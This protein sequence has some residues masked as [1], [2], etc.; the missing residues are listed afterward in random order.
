M[1]E[2]AGM[3]EAVH[4]IVRAVTVE[5]GAPLRGSTAARLLQPARF[6]GAELRADE[7]IYA[8]GEIAAVDG[9]LGRLVAMYNAAAHDVAG[10]PG[11]IADE[12]W[13]S[14]PAAL[15]ATSHRVDG[16][17]DGDRLT[18]HWPS[19]VGADDA[20]WLLLPTSRGC[21]VLVPRS[22]VRVDATDTNTGEVAVHDARIEEHHVVT[23][24]RDRVAVIAAAGMA[25]AV[26]GSADGVWRKHVEQTRGRL[27]TSYGGEQVTTAASAQLARAASDIDAARLQVATS[28]GRDMT[29]VTWACAQAVGRARGAA[30]LL[31]GSSRHALN[32]A[33]PVTG[34]WKAVHAGARVALGLFG[35]L[36][37]QGGLADS[38]D[39]TDQP[40]R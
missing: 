28:L 30:D 40:G 36:N 2:P 13:G 11:D 14:D 32:A 18:G 19:V 3:H 9:A 20:D 5:P 23:G 24:P 8:V 12:I 37:D 10:L 27:A 31:L 6:G 17:L 26:V 29:A 22:A 39:S 1:A 21:R 7:F 34:Q 33:D 16:G 38:A 35:E 15:I 25:A 4:E